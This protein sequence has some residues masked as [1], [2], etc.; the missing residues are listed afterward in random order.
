MGALGK[1]Y[2]TRKEA[3]AH[4]TGLGYLISPR[5]LARL[6][7]GGG[8]PPYRLFLKRLTS[9]GR[10]DLELWAKTQSVERGLMRNPKKVGALSDISK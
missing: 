6:A 5:T 10:E 2:L 3:A 7:V 8:G 4:L 9:Y 1:E